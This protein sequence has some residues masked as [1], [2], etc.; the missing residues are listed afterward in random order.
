MVG[1]QPTAC[2]IPRRVV[3]YVVL[4]SGRVEYTLSA[5]PDCASDFVDVGH[6]PR[7]HLCRM[8]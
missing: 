7:E 4:V 2:R 6:V 8:P 1:A 3:G 5:I